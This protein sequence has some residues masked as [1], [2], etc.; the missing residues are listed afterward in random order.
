[1]K[2][3]ILLGAALALALGGAGCGGSAPQPS[4][5][6][7]DHA[8]NGMIPANTPNGSTPET[9][10][11]MQPTGESASDGIPQYPG[12]NVISKNETDK[13]IVNAFSSVDTA[14]TI[15]AWYG[16]T[17]PAMGYASKE[18]KSQGDTISK[19]YSDAH[20]LYIVNTI[21]QGNEVPKTL[22][23]VTRTDQTKLDQ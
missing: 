21:D 1:M 18:S 10:R 12:A 20:Y 5:N 15:Q 3:T 8:P 2:K 4:A 6:G 11:I 9:G 14:D 22:F 23:S 17:L 13:L 19:S 7:S 16:Q